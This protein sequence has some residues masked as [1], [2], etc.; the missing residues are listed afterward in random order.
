MNKAIPKVD[1]KGFYI[2]DVE[3]DD[4][5]TGVVPIYAQPEPEKAPDLPEDR[6]IED[7]ADVSEEPEQPREIIGYLVGITLP[8][9]LYHPRFDLFTWNAYQDAVLEAQSDYADELHDWREQWAEGVEQGPEPVYAPP[10]QP[11]NLWIEGLTPE[12]IAEL[13]KP[14]ELSEIEILKKENMLLKAQ[15]NAITERA[16]FIEDIIAEMAMHIYQ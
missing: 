4:S 2:E 15:N 8:N 7:E 6:E 13:T 11:D 3:P 12:E 1:L 10:A 14:G 16:D 5:L 9:G